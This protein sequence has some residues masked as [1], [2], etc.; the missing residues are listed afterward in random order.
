MSSALAPRCPPAVSGSSTTIPSGRRPWLRS[1]RR[2]TTRAART[3]ETMGTRATSGWPF[4]RSGSARGRPA[5]Q[6]TTFA[7]ASQAAGTTRSIHRAATMQLIPTTPP[8]DRAT[9]FETSSR[10]AISL[11][12]A[13]R[14]PRGSPAPKPMPAVA[15]RP[16]P[17][18]RATAPASL[19]AETR[20]P[21]PPWTRGKGTVWRPSFRRGA[22][23][24]LLRDCPPG[25]CGGRR[26][27][28]CS[29]HGAGVGYR[30]IAAALREVHGVSG[31]QERPEAPP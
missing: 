9:A 3:E 15:T 7:P 11:A 25:G 28:A 24:M 1:Q 27:S 14:S 21:I 4:T 20:T 30:P 8:P 18:Q 22:G 5:P 19:P 17:P 13:S 6:T 23:R 26:R 31:R 10:V 2:A 12:S 29:G 16:T